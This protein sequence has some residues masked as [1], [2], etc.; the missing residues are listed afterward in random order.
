MAKKFGTPRR[1]VLL[2]SAG[3]PVAAV[4]LEVA[5]DPC[6]VLLSS[7]GLLARTANGEPFGGRATAKRAKHDVIV[8]AVPATARGEVGAVTSAGPAAAA[9]RDRSAA[10]AGDA[11]RRPTWRAARRSRSSCP[12]RT[13]RRLV[14]LTTLDES[15][16]GLALGTEQGVVKRVV[17][18]YP[19]NKE[20]LEVIT[21]K[22]GDRIVGAVELRTGEE[23]LVFITDDAQLLRY[24]A[25]PGPPAGPAGGRHGGHQAR[26]R[27]RR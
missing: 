26:R 8:S 2:E 25:S 7:T 15:S 21:L 24:P 3:A 10:A 6:R 9:E 20:E 12:W 17:P 22:E 23:D 16:P 5:D 19:A 27:A 1:T 14:C 18:D 4:P 11:L 13:T